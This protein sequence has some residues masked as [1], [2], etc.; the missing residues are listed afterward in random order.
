M[1]REISYALTIVNTPTNKIIFAIRDDGVITWNCYGRMRTCR[2]A[3]DVA[4]AMAAGLKK[5][6]EI[7]KQL[8]D[9]TDLS[10]S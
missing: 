3:K 2:S 6:L 8:E 7:N 5:L 9:Q 10:T 4:L 1:R